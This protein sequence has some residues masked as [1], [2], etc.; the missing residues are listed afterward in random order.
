MIVGGRFD[1][2]DDEGKLESIT[3]FDKGYTLSLD[4]TLEIP[5][6]VENI[7]DFPYYLSAPGT[8]IFEDGLPTVCGGVNFKTNPYTYHTEC[9]KF[10]FANAW[11]LSGSMEHHTHYGKNSFKK[12]QQY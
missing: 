5:S 4:P 7:C 8:A 3:S 1:S 9:Y 2:F 11:S 12:E 6:C 10:S